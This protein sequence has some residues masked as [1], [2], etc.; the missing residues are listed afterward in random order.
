[1]VDIYRA[2]RCFAAI[3]DELCH[4]ES[5]IAKQAK[6]R[7]ED[8]ALYCFTRGTNRNFSDHILAAIEYSLVSIGGKS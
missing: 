5:R 2:I 6:Y 3:S 1:M 7:L 8:S 4:S